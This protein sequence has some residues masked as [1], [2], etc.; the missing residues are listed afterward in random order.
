MICT[1]STNPCVSEASCILLHLPAF[2]CTEFFCPV[3]ALPWSLCTCS[4]RLTPAC[5][6]APPQLSPCTLPALRLIGSR[7]SPSG[8]CLRATL[9]ADPPSQHASML[10]TLPQVESVNL[11]R[12]VALTKAAHSHEQHRGQQQLGREPGGKP[13]ALSKSCARSGMHRAV[14]SANGPVSRSVRLRR[15][16]KGKALV[17]HWHSLPFGPA[18]NRLLTRH[19]SR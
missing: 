14:W 6:P 9:P 1:L 2:A 17:L 16:Q 19:G 18:A 12:A 8:L 15:A 13:R 10:S 4:S 7:C 3:S 11:R 5:S